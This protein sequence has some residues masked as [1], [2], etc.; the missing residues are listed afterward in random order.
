MERG[1]KR[2]EYVQYKRIQILYLWRGWCVFKAG[3]RFAETALRHF[4]IPDLQGFFM[5]AATAYCAHKLKL[6]YFAITDLDSAI[7]IHSFI[8]SFIP[9]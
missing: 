6:L 8:H 4:L 9:V 1:L 5:R 3:W 2:T 7:I